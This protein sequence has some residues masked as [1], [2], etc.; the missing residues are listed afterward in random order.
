LATRPHLRCLVRA[1]LSSPQPTNVRASPARVRAEA[2]PPDPTRKPRDSLSNPISGPVLATPFQPRLCGPDSVVEPEEGP[3]RQITTRRSSDS[4][5]R[6]CGSGGFIHPGT[7]N[8]PEGP[9]VVTFGELGAVPF[10]SSGYFGGTGSPSHLDAAIDWTRRWRRRYH[11]CRQLDSGVLHTLRWW[12]VFKLRNTAATY[13]RRRSLLPVAAKVNS[14]SF[15]SSRASRPS[16]HGPG[17]A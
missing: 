15:G 9:Q 8:P 1:P 12:T 10:L 4:S 6:Y 5:C 11:D 14:P 13:W 17:I 16:P 2:T 3:A 7:W